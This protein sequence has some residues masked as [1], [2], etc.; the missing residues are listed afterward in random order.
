M[1]RLARR[2]YVVM[3][4]A[5]SSRPGAVRYSLKAPSSRY[6]RRRTR[7]AVGMTH[8]LPAPVRIRREGGTHRIAP[9]RTPEAG[10]RLPRPSS[11]PSAHTVHLP[12]RSTLTV[13]MT[14]DTR[15]L[16]ARTAHQSLPRTL[17][18]SHFAAGCA[19]MARRAR[20]FRR[21]GAS[22]FAGEAR[23]ASRA[24][25]ARRDRSLSDGV[26]A[27]ANKHPKRGGT[28]RRPRCAP[29]RRR[30][31]ACSQ[32]EVGPRPPKEACAGRGSEG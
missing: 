1:L 32:L 15:R 21:A 25:T 3:T 7:A 28:L 24:R 4:A 12:D 13:S 17:P 16:G 6:P 19:C 5:P 8:R 18:S 22:S 29:P 30:R 27:E 23:A 31:R 20:A 11:A 26:P 9:R 14:V 2:T 10:A